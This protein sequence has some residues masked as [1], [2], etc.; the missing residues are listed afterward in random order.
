MFPGTRKHIQIRWSIPQHYEKTLAR[1]LISVVDL[2]DRKRME[3]ELGN[4]QR[5]HALGV[6]AGGIAHDFNSFLTA[7]RVNISMA[8]IYGELAEDISQM[9]ADAEKASLRAKGLTQQLLTFSKGGEPINKTIS[10]SAFPQR[11]LCS[12]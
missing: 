1:L 4:I 3:Q 6:L 7:I 2:T 11:V 5:L 10:I 9:L 12:L 8:R